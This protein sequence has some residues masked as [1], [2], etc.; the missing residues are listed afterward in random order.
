MPPEL[1]P[2]LERFRYMLENSPNL[3]KLTLD[4][5]GPIAPMTEFGSSFI[6]SYLS[7]PAKKFGP[8]RLPR[9]VRHLLRRA[10]YAPRTFAISTSSISGGGAGSYPVFQSS[11]WEISRAP[12]VNTLLCEY[13][14]DK[15]SPTILEELRWRGE[16][17]P[18]CIS[19]C[20]RRLPLV[21][22]L[23]NFWNP[24]RLCR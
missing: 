24:T 17:E 2:S 15:A 5:A 1:G 18:S 4:G 22:G 23:T 9:D 14:E 7:P 12:H 6:P 3:E 13:S 20:M 8:W 21:R 16:S 11:H 10:L 19:G